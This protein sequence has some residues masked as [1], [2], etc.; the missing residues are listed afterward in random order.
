MA[1]DDRIPV[2]QL[3]VGIF[4]HLDL[5]WM[6]HPFSF[7]SFKIRS[8]DQIHT[9]RELGLKTVRWS[10]D[11]SDAKPVAPGAPA[12]AAAD[13]SATAAA[14]AETP[15]LDPAIVA[16]KQARIQRLAEHR[17]RIARVEKEFVRSAKIVGSLGQTIFSL[18]DQTLTAATGLVDEMVATL[19]SSPD[20]AIH[21]MS[22]HPGADDAYSHPLNVSV[23]AMILARELRLPPELVHIVG[24]GA[25]FHDIG[26][27][28]VPPRIVNNPGPLNKAE[29]EFFEMHCQYG[30]EIGKKAGLPAGTLKII[31]Q[32]HELFDGSGYPAKLKGEAIDLTAR[33][34]SLVDA[35][36][37]FC[38]PPNPAQAATPHEA[39]SQMFAQY[40]NRFDPKLLQLFIRFM[41]VY[42]AGTVVTLSNGAL[43]MVIAVDAAHP[44]QPTVVV[45]DPDVPKSEAIVLDLAEEAEVNISRA[46][47]PDKLLPM[48]FDYLSP[49]RRLSF[50]FDS[51]RTAD[52]A[53]A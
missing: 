17:E 48:V 1:S 39:L 12:D 22:E 35:F 11:R 18:P 15:A 29:R 30:L 50:Y 27:A 26:L 34:V 38:N 8:A 20:L 24:M 19:V 28:K 42:P 10:P 3:Q 44:L 40:R 47:R 31:Y 43:G 5:G 41:G 16:A 49:R 36:D 45:Y 32:H 13:A 37:S 21:V 33:I 4:V 7:N 2:E 14:T 53:P 51:G 46:I 9:I 52:G 6:A 25:L 23:L